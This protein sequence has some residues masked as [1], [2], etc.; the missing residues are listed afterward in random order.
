[1]KKRIFLTGASSG[2]GRA[3][4]ELLVA[5]GHE[6]WGTSR[7]STRVPRMERLHAV[8]LDL[9]ERGSIA[10]A[11]ASALAEARAFDVVINNAGSGHFGAAESLAM[12]ELQ[13]QFQTLVFG[14]IELCHL[15][16]AAMRKERS[17]LIINVTSL[18]SQLPVPFM[19]SYNAAKA[20]MASY[21]MSLQLELASSRIRAVDLEPGDIRTRFNDVAV[22]GER[23]DPRIARAWQIADNN[24]KKAPGPELVAKHIADLI[25]RA[26][27]PPRIIVGDV[28]QSKI[29][30][31]VNRLLPQRLRLWGLRK[32][33]RI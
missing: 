3:T 6:V 21:T 7:D 11:F 22:I 2:V 8:R 19:A 16:L 29:A 33:Y 17:G 14:H 27:P 30:P 28:F 25:G 1:M 13:K 10:G 20:A 18:A 4:A 15:A 32:Y 23:S 5:R 12:E 24:M 9:C 26:N 31:V